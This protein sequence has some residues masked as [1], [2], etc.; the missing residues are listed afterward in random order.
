VRLDAWMQ[1]TGDPL[2]N[3][4]VP[5]PSDALVNDSAG[6]SPRETPIRMK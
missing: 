6:R 2:V 4:P 3:G 1:R 5:A